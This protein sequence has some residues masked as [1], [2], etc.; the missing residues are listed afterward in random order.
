M[1]FDLK[2]LLERRKG[3]AVELHRQHMNPVLAD[4]LGFI[5][6][7][8]EYARGQGVWLETEDGARVLDALSG[9]GVFALGR[10]HPGIVDAIRQ[11]LELDFPTLV[12]MDLPLLS[13]LLAEALIEVAPP[14]LD[15]VFFTNS[16]AEAVEGAIKFARCATGRPKI[17]FHKGAFH[18][19][20]CGSLSLNGDKSF[21]EGFGELLPGC[22]SIDL[23]NLDDVESRLRME[24]VAAV[25][26]EPIRGKGVYYPDDNQV[27]PTLQ[28]LCR[29]HG[30]LLVADE[31]QCGLGRTGRMWACEHW[32]LEPDILLTAKAL[33][34]G[35][36][37]A[38]A[39]LMRREIQRG[40]F[41]RLDRCVVHSSTFGQNGLAMVAGL[42]TLRILKSEGVIENA[43][44]MG[45][46]LLD[47]L[48]ALTERHEFA[49]A[50]R[51]KGLMVA[52]ELGPP[53]SL[54]K[55]AA[56]AILNKA[57]NGLFAQA[58][59]MRLYGQHHILTQVAGHHLEVIKLLPPLVID[60]PEIDSIVV[61]F[62]EVL[63]SAGRFPGPV[64]Q[65]ATRLVGL[66]ASNLRR[67]AS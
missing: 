50:A 51:G 4:V 34:G 53:K 46:R 21:R 67:R 29:R 56:W 9:Y 52:L 32:G 60:E 62:D 26:I 55:K 45:S 30:T 1:D 8:P 59:V 31:V 43:A 38:G 15:A 13:G 36:I 19:L 11:A 28:E 41:S 66:A 54:G 22:E 57:E 63:E 64:W 2:A 20:T 35:L 44:R 24:D 14:G 27:Y 39:I 40:V 61:A 33:S 10:N 65:V 3:E 47:G 48:N 58:L 42:A 7:E 49:L 16:G 5:G 25:V 6:F 17:L 12:Q 37:P 18:G 23:G